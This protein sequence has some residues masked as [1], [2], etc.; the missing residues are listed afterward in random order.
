MTNLAF[1]VRWR[2]R[3]LIQEQGA[4]A[5]MNSDIGRKLTANLAVLETAQQQGKAA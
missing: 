1:E 5:V 3:E 2:L 4:A